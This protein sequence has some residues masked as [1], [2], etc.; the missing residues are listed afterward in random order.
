MKEKVEKLI[1]DDY[2]DE[3][4]DMQGWDKEDKEEIKLKAIEILLILKYF[5]ESHSREN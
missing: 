5:E 2:L 3:I 1:N 4:I